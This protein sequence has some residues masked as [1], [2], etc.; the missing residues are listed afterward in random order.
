MPGLSKDPEKRARQL[1]GLQRGRIAQA[2]AVLAGL[3]DEPAKPKPRAAAPRDTQPPA[4]A[5]EVP[6]HAYPDIPEEPTSDPAQPA[7]G[8]DPDPEPEPRRRRG[9]LDG[10]RTDILG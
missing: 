7:A 8:R 5:N 3:E 4:P 2:R 10:L 1:D 9:L 6:T